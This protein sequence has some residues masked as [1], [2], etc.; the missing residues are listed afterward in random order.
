MKRSLLFSIILHIIV[1]VSAFLLYTPEK[2]KKREPFVAHI[3]TPEIPKTVKQQPA[4]KPKVLPPPKSMPK[5]QPEKVK[6]YPA[7]PKDLPPPKDLYAEPSGKYATPADKTKSEKT[8][9]ATQQEDGSQRFTKESPASKAMKADPRYLDKPGVDSAGRGESI[10]EP[11]TVT[12]REKL[13]DKQI[14][15]GLARKY[16]EAEQKRDNSI[17]FSAKEFKYHG[18]MQRLKEKIESSWKYPLEAARQGIY[19]DLFIQFT[20]RK[21]G[22]LGAI[23]LA[24][25]SGHKLLDDAAIKAIRDA[26]PYWELP[27]SWAE[28]NITITAHFIYSLYGTFIR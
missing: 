15:G 17:T 1:L 28:D 24:R 4:A 22:E 21:N 14:I 9:P 26:A 13:F 25:T 7:L 20:I 27:S 10:K 5:Q 18:Y 19:G 3:V 11:S 2:L 16:A 12:N 8:E 6:R 23:T